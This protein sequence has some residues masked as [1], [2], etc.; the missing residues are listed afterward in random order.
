VDFIYG[1]NSINRIFQGGIDSNRL[2]TFLEMNMY[3]VQGKISNMKD[4]D[5]KY[6]SKAD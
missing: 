4:F 3:D 6:F 5:I 2:K 1:I